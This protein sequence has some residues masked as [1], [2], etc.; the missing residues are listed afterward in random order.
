[1]NLDGK[2]DK[3]DIIDVLPLTKDWAFASWSEGKNAVE[4]LREQLVIR[5]N[6][7]HELIVAKQRSDESLSSED[8]HFYVM[9]E[10]IANEND[11]GQRFA[12]MRKQVASP[13]QLVRAGSFNEIVGF[14]KKADELIK[15]YSK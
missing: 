5:V 3:S 13:G 11:N 7:L 10:G 12:D 1:M 4:R 6:R 2:K 15:K 14:I 9:I 8:E